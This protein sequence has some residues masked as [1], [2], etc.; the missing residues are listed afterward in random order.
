MTS[1]LIIDADAHLTEDTKRVAALTDAR[2][3][4]YAPHLIDQGPGEL[5]SVG[6]SYLSQAPGFSWGDTNTPGGL[7]EGGRRMRK[8]GESDPLGFDAKLRLRMM[9]DHGVAAAVIFPSLGL[10]TGAIRDPRIAAGVCRGINRYIAE[11]CAADTSRLWNTATL[12]IGEVDLAVAEARYA[13]KELGAKLL[14]APSGLHFQFPLY[15]PH[16]DPLFD[17]IAELGVPF[18]THTGGALI[19]PGLGN[20][21]FQGRWA[22]FHITTHSIEAQLAVLGFLS[23]GVLER[24]PGLKVGFF[25]AACGWVPFI[26]QAIEGKYQGMRWLMPEMT[27]SPTETFARQ[28]LVTAE[29]EDGLIGT[30]LAQL[31]GKG[32]AWSSD[33]PHFDCGE[34]AG[35]PTPLL[36]TSALDATQKRKVLCDN[37]LAF[38]GIDASKLTPPR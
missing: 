28:C 12:P 5:L 34:T 14:F 23:Y 29:A 13:V 27:R 18:G 35:R 7:R 37:I 25:E 33:V 30:V 3:R 11:F 32:V 26:L 2:Y 8:W 19:A 38:L 21:R 1:S 6:G 4:M 22:P 10:T 15:H 20:D 17:A 24:R 16:Y 9:D 36:E 31:D